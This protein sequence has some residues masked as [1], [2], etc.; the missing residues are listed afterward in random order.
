MT[1][2]YPHRHLLAIE[3][4][5]PPYIAD[6]LELAGKAKSARVTSLTFVRSSVFDPANPDFAYIQEQVRLAIAEA[7]RTRHALGSGPAA[8]TPATPGA[9][10]GTPATGTPATGTPATGTPATG[11]KTGTK[12]GTKAG[13][14]TAVKGATAPTPTPTPTPTSAAA[15]LDKV[16]GY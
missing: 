9:T 2:A 16:C 12:A 6:L 1:L 8:T 5:E 13:T 4:L 15:S 3:G 10:T 11:T 14:K 7:T